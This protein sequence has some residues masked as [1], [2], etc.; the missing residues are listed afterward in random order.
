MA[1]EIYAQLPADL[2]TNEVL[3]GLNLNTAGDLAT[4]FLDVKGKAS[5]YEGKVKEYEGQITNLQANSIPKLPENATPEQQ[6]AFFKALGRPD[7]AEEYEFE[8]EDKNSPEWTK[9]WKDTFHQLG[10]PKE[11]AKQLSAAWNGSMQKIVETHNANVQ[12]EI[13]GAAEKLKTE[14]GEKYDAS[15]ELTKRLFKTYMKDEM[16]DLDKAFTGETTATRYTIIKLLLN[17]AEKTGEDTSLHGHQSAL[18]AKNANDAL[19]PNSPAP[20][21]R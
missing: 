5:E 15:V 6:A 14:L 17:I 16:A 19:F 13:Q 1:G 12:Q 8:G 4:A 2:Q 10:I 9:Q 11:T 3:T 21:K 7:K 20:P 18:A